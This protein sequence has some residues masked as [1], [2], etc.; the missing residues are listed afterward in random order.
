MRRNVYV[1]DMWESGQQLPASGRCGYP[2]LLFHCS[3]HV[4]DMSAQ[5][6]ASTPGDTFLVDLEVLVAATCICGA[7]YAAAKAN[8]LSAELE[9]LLVYLN[10]RVF[11][12]CLGLSLPIHKSSGYWYLTDSVTTP[13]FVK[14]GPEVHWHLLPEVAVIPAFYALQT[15]AFWVSCLFL[16][17]IA[18][19]RGGLQNVAVANSVCAALIPWR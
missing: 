1:S 19:L 9:Q 16:S 17:S 5:D 2:C 4:L 15:L 12:P 3:A 18:G 14:L 13:V 11:T 6:C 10:R 7:G 8:L